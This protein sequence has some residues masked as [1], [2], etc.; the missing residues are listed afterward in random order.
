MQPRDIKLA[1]VCIR[2]W[3]LPLRS[4]KKPNIFLLTFPRYTLELSLNNEGRTMSCIQ[5]S[6]RHA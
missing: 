3:P 5:R 4:E 2:R 1:G 6:P